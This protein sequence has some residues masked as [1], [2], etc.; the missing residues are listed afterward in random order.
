VGAPQG[1]STITQQLARIKYLS[2]ER[3]LRRKVQEVMIA[4]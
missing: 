4:L 1:A 3:S 2:P